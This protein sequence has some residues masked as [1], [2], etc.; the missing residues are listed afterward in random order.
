M[1]ERRSRRVRIFSVM[2]W[3]ALFQVAAEALAMTEFSTP[4]IGAAM[5]RSFRWAM[6]EVGGG[7]SWSPAVSPLELQIGG[8]VD[9]AGSTTRAAVRRVVTAGLEDGASVSD[10]QTELMRAAAFRPA[11]ALMIARTET[12]R[13]LSAGTEH[14]L[15]LALAEGIIVRRQW[16]SARDDAV[17]DTHRA[18]DGQ[19]IDMPERFSSPSGARAKHPGGFGV[20]AEDINC[21]CTVLPIVD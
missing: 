5:R 20:A 7:A 8:L 10:M 3:A 14:A 12:T 13:A 6:S 17:R 21:R 15:E 1:P 18:M 11:R 4:I 2:E 9:H 16:L 19:T